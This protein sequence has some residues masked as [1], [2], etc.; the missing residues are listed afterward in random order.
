MD[1]V[2]IKGSNIP[3]LRT[4]LDAGLNLPTRSLGGVLEQVVPNYSN[5][6]PLFTTTYLDDTLRIS[7]DQDGKLFVYTKQSDATDPTDYSQ[8]S[9][10]LGIGSLL[11]GIPSF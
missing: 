5:P 10:D 8:V 2:E 1:T 6:Q 11:Q 4:V 7:R 3:L 9:A